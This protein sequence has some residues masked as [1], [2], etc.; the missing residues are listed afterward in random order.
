ML[1]GQ[2][3]ESKIMFIKGRIFSQFKALKTEAKFTAP[4]KEELNH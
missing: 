4:L 1:K 3:M 2:F